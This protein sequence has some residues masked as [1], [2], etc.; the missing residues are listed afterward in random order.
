VLSYKASHPV[1]PVILSNLIPSDVFIIYH[2]DDFTPVCENQ[3]TY[4]RLFGM[5]FFGGFGK[6]LTAG[7]QWLATRKILKNR[8]N[9]KAKYNFYFAKHRFSCQNAPKRAC[10]FCQY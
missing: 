3:K 10:F 9:T 7:W 5:I 8:Q 6:M 1:H 2:G 4:R